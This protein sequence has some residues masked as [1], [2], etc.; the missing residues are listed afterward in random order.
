MTQDSR[1][2]KTP[3]RQCLSLY[4]RQLVFFKCILKNKSYRV[5]WSAKR[6]SNIPWIHHI[7]HAC[8]RSKIAWQSSWRHKLSHAQFTMESR[9]GFK[10]S[11]KVQKKKPACRDQNQ[12]RK[13]ERKQPPVVSSVQRIA[14]TG[15][16]WLQL[17][18]TLMPHIQCSNISELYFNSLEALYRWFLKG[19]C[20]TVA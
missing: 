8:A 6:K 10:K 19:I 4:L 2:Y 9:Q 20:L 11:N 16:S 13:H 15:I 3:M 1:F 18:S 17:M 7:W 12:C 14:V 5:C